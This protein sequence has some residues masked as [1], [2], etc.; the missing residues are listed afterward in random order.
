MFSDPVNVNAWKNMCDPYIQRC[1][2]G[3]HKQGIDSVFPIAISEICANSKVSYFV[4]VQKFKRA[5]CN[6]F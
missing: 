2:N 6:S 1:E 5:A 3:E 4:H